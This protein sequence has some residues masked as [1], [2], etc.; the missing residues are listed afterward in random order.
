VIDVQ[1]TL[2]QLEGVVVSSTGVGFVADRGNFA[3]YAFDDIVTRTGSLP[4]DR[5]IEGN[6]TELRSPRQMFLYE[7]E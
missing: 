5:A 1:A 4:P 3:I 6:L 7:P 2:P